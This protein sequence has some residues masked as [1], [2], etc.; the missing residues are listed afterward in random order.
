MVQSWSRSTVAV[1]VCVGRFDYLKLWQRRRRKSRL[2]V[3]SD[4]QERVYGSLFRVDVWLHIW[5]IVAQ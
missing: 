3:A 5:P 2:P 1:C 4:T